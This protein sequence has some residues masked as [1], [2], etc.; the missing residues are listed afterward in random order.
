MSKPQHYINLGEL[1]LEIL[2]QVWEKTPASV[3]DIHE[4]LQ[5]KRD[6]AYTTVMTVM[7]RLADKGVLKRSQEGRTYIY[8]AQFSRNEIAFSFIDRVQRKIFQGSATELFSSLIDRSA[9][10]ND[11]LS[12]LK[13][14]IEEKEKSLNG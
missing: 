14:M 7:S 9:F 4:E 5:K 2:D 3:K 11:D 6:I 12:V 8:K 13:A 1:E 10:S